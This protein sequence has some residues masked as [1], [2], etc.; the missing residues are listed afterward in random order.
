MVQEA[1]AWQVTVAECGWALTAARA[2]ASL[3]IWSANSRT[4]P[5]YALSGLLVPMCCGPDSF[6]PKPNVPT[7]WSEPSCWRKP[8]IHAIGSLPESAQPGRL[9]TFPP[10]TP[11]TLASTGSRALFSESGV[12]TA[13]PSRSLY[14]PSVLT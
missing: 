1:P 10:L 11:V 5:T 6:Q 13:T 9:A 2:A 14:L 3:V 12:W 4:V 7:D 8:P